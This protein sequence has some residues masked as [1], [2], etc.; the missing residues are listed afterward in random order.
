M[1]FD[2]KSTLFSSA[3]AYAAGMAFP[4]LNISPSDM[5]MSAAAA[6]LFK[7]QLDL[8]LAEIEP[9]AV[10]SVTGGLLSPFVGGT[11]A[12]IGTEMLVRGASLDSDLFK[13]AALGGVA[14]SAATYA[15]R[16]LISSI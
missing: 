14:I 8:I 12:I 3:A 10:K 5:A 2:L 16:T 7:V 9:P 4:T 6:S 15:A 11:A 13:H 1:S